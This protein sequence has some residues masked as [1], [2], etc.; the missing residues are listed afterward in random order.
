MND[1]SQVL[2]EFDRRFFAIPFGNSD[3]Q[4]RKF[5][6]EAQY[7]PERAYRALGL[8]LADRLNALNE[9]RFNL[10][11]REVDI[12]ELQEKLAGELPKFD[13][14]R[15]EIDLAEKQST[16]NYITKMVNDA[17]AEVATLWG[18]IQKF[19]EFTREQFEAAEQQHFE[20]RLKRQVQGVTGAIDSL[21]LITKNNGE[22][23]KMLEHVKTQ[24][25]VEK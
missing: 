24:M 12:E 10:Q 8:R 13:R 18:E 11:R 9:A 21:D 22:F 1:V 4:N 23:S 3:F 15:L 20:I 14:R 6:M 2:S 17:L 25:I 19:P 16:A 7:T 5:V